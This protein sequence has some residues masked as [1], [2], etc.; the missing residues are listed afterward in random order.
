MSVGVIAAFVSFALMARMVWTGAD[1][2]L[3]GLILVGMI[4]GFGVF[5]CILG[6]HTWSS[7]YTNAAVK[8]F[9]SIF[10]GVAKLWKKNGA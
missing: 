9:L 7:E 8:D 4:L 2:T 1:I 3:F 10:G 6:A 5:L